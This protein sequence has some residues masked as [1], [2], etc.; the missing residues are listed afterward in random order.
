MFHKTIALINTFY[1]RVLVQK[2]SEAKFVEK[3]TLP[4]LL[5]LSKLPFLNVP[6]RAAGPTMLLFETVR[7]LSLEAKRMLKFLYGFHLCVRKQNGR[8]SIFKMIYQ[9][10]TFGGLLLHSKIETSVLPVWEFTFIFPNVKLKIHYVRQQTWYVSKWKLK[11]RLESLQ[12]SYIF[13]SFT[14]FHSVPQTLHTS[15]CK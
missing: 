11:C 4:V 3:L 2:E 15:K 10:Y 14:D 7:C 9:G 5:D 1:S 8:F 13:I 6:L 12:N